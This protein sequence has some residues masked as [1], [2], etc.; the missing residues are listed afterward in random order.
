[1][2][3][4]RDAR[5]AGSIVLFVQHAPEFWWN[6]EHAEH[7]RGCADRGQGQRTPVVSDDR[8]VHGLPGSDIYRTALTLVIEEF[9]RG[10]REASE[11]VAALWPELAV[12]RQ[13]VLAA[14]V[15]QRPDEHAVHDGVREHG[16]RGADRESRDGRQADCRTARHRAPGMPHIVDDPSH[17]PAPRIY[18][19]HRHRRSWPDRQ[20]QAIPGRAD[21]RVQ[22]SASRAT[23]VVEVPDIVEDLGGALAGSTL[24]DPQQDG[25]AAAADD[26][27]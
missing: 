7:V 25:A 20:G 1:V 6:I 22:A 26:P 23:L 5:R 16:Q 12:D 13:Q 9:G 3:E 14:R 19:R 17:R 8:H 21:A 2:T 24:H 27:D 18:V 10:Q 4:H 15:R 11:G